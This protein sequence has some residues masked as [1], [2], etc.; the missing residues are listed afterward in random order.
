MREPFV[1]DEEMMVLADDSAS[2]VI[3][4]TH[5]A[6]FNKGSQFLKDI[7][8][9]FPKYFNK[10]CYNCLDTTLTK[11][12]YE[13]SDHHVRLA[14]SA[15]ALPQLASQKIY[16][17][18]ETGKF[19]NDVY[20]HFLTDKYK[21]WSLRFTKTVMENYCDQSNL[22]YSVIADALTGKKVCE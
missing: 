8:D 7:I 21:F 10:D 22:L 18:Y 6:Y 2:A 20:N 9:T 13:K 5:Y 15:T 17:L 16:K 11:Y 1:P 12:V 3:P 19:D 14:S 4:T